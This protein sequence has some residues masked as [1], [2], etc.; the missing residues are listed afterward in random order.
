MAEH[1]CP[2]FVI[3]CM[4]HRI[5]KALKNLL[6][7]LRVELGEFDRVTV[8]GGAGNTGLLFYHLDLS[9]RLHRPDT[10]VLTCHEDCG[11]GATKEDLLTAFRRVR[12]ELPEEDTV[13]AFW[14]YRREDGQWDSEEVFLDQ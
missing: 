14:I 3:G 8:A 12:D 9:Q 10:F 1:H 6:E 7:D 2:G 4:D 13:R 5:Q 11:Y